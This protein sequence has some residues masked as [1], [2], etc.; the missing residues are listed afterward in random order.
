VI[1]GLAAGLIIG[2]ALRHFFGEARAVRAEEAADAGARALLETRR[3]LESQLQRKLTRAEATKLFNAYQANLIQL[4][5]Q[6]DAGGRWSRKR[7][8]LEKLLG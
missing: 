8:G 6:Q 5:F 3:S 1:G 4:G 7:S 2:T